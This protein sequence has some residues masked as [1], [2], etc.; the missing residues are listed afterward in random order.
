MDKNHYSQFCF[1]FD[2]FDVFGAF[3]VFSVS[4]LHFHTGD[5]TFDQFPSNRLRAIS[6]G[7]M[8]RNASQNKLSQNDKIS[9]V[10]KVFT[11]DFYHNILGANSQA[12]KQ[13]KLNAHV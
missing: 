12:V 7:Q 8:R 3:G 11:L 4:Y 1:E 5:D 9:N 10:F 2:R 13:Y 6:D